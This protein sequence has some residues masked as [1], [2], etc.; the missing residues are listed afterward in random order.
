MRIKK[1]LTSIW[2]EFVYGGH[3]LSLG[4]AGIVCSV[5]ILLE[6]WPDWQILLI[7]YL[8]TQITYNY[9]HFKEKEVD[10]RTNPER[11]NYLQ[12]LMKYFPLIFSF[13]ILTLFI[14][15]A[16]FANFNT[17]LF[18]LFLAMGGVLFTK[19]FKGLTRALPGFKNFYTAAF[20]TTGIF[21]PFFY[22]SFFPNLFFILLILFFFYLRFFIG[23]SFSDIKDIEIDTKGGLLTLAVVFG[24]EKLINL[25]KCLNVLSAI[26]IIIGV[27]YHFLPTYSLMLVFSIPYSFYYLKKAEEKN[28]NTAFLYNIVVDSEII[29]WLLFIIIGKALL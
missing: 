29:T 19:Y 8:I 26:P 3:L 12:G 2:N 16:L 9:N 6:K 1:I 23:T 25:L 18:I 15:L 11:V 5:M 13:Y 14:I 27:Y 21:L 20:W 22:Y 7:A 17:I 28:F 4:A 10:L 24:K